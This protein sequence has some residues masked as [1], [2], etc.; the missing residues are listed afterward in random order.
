[1]PTANWF[2]LF[3]RIRVI[4]CLSVFVLHANL[5]GFSAPHDSFGV[6]D[7]I[8]AAGHL[9]V[10]VFFALSAFLLTLHWEQQRIGYREYLTRRA[11]R[12]AP[13]Y[14]ASVAFVFLIALLMTDVS[15]KDWFLSLLQ[16]ALFLAGTTSAAG[17]NLNQPYWSLSVEMAFYITLPVLIM[18][19]RYNI[20]TLLVPTL[21]FAF[22]WK[23][24]TVLRAPVMDDGT[25]PLFYAAPSFLFNFACGMVTA[26]WWMNG[27]R[28]PAFKWAAS[29]LAVWLMIVGGD[30]DG[31]FTYPITALL[32]A[33]FVMS[34]ADAKMPGSPAW[35][36]GAGLSYGFYLWHYFVIVLLCAYGLNDFYALI[37]LGIPITAGVSWLSYRFIES[38]I[39]LL[40]GRKLPQPARKASNRLKIAESGKR[41]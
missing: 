18:A 23:Y 41:Q 14:Y 31:P 4:A 34:A 9:A 1:M 5:I 10:D 27:V 16:H 17:M 32:C 28:A 35:R 12:I 2:P 37:L 8:Y 20:W 38:E 26:Q 13:A 11:L 7:R 21:L 25:I 24:L 36:L 29:C 19:M 30:V 15:M 33:W 39:V 40:I 3:D 6:V 22:I